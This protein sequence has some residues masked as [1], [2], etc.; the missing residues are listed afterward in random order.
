MGNLKEEFEV[1]VDPTTVQQ[2]ASWLKKLLAALKK[3]VGPNG[4][5]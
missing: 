5:A 3:L 2:Q 1:G 4:Q